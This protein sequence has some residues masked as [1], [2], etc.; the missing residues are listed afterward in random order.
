MKRANVKRIVVISAAP[1][2]A[3][4]GM[5]QRVAF[6][7]LWTLL[8]DVYS[9]LRDMESVL[10]KSD[11]DWTIARPPRLTDGPLTGAYRTAI[12]RN[13]GSVISRAD[14]AREMLRALDEPKTIHHTVGIAV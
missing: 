14:L 1:L 7:I 13:V 3:P 9:D 2:G 6:A 8:R 4:E 5:F 10:E 12:D 11:A